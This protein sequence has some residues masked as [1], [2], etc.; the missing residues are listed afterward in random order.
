MRI[1]RGAVA[2]A[3]GLLSLSLAACGG[4]TGS[5]SESRGKVEDNTLDLVASVY[6]L[7]YVLQQ[8]AGDGFLT[9]SLAAK[10][11][12]PHDMELTPKN[13]KDIEKADLVLTLNGFQPAVDAATKDKKNVMDAGPSVDLVKRNGAIDYH[14]WLDPARMAALSD[15]VAKRLGEID[16]DQAGQFTSNAAAFQQKLAGLNNSI[17]VQLATCKYKDVF[18]N[19][20]AFGYLTTKAGL[21]ERG[22]VGTNPEAE[23]TPTQ[24]AAAV[25][26]I[27]E[28]KV[29]TI[30][31]EPLASDK[32]IRTIAE[33]TGVNVGV[34]DPIEGLSD[35]GSAL[36]YLDLMN[37]NLS[38]LELGQ[39]C[40][41]ATPLATD[42][43]NP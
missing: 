8:V 14:F 35:K 12:E 40:A 6:P 34:L 3:A 23:P 10:N 37:D 11:V 16:P 25:K 42:G 43:S 38:T 4:N 15:A 29:P 32:T 21:T 17:K 18:T 13:V 33:E 28:T 36:D 39:K 24:V 2:L 9:S 1:S 19:H 7:Q 5:S 30:Y 41:T 31:S 20:A 26:Q 27:R 22:V